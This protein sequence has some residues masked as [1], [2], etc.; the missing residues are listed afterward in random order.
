M[1]FYHR[2]Y[3]FDIELLKKMI[4]LGNYVAFFPEFLFQEDIYRR[5]NEIRC[6]PISDNHIEIEVGYI[7]NNKYKLSSA[8]ELFLKILKDKI[9]KLAQNY[10]HH[11]LNI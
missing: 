11:L 3:L 5:Y 2:M 9:E 1:K 8:D 7:Y 10:P 6:I 4:A